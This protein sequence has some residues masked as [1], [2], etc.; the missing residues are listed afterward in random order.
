MKR[1]RFRQHQSGHG[2]LGTSNPADKPF[3]IAAYISGLVHY[4]ACSRM[5]LER[6]WRN[7]RNNLTENSVSNIVECGE[8]VVANVNADAQILKGTLDTCEACLSAD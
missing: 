6:D 1:Q 7:L 8:H 5:S 2:A 3:Y 4:N